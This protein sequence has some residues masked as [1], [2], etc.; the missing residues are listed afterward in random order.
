[1]VGTNTHQVFRSD[2]FVVVVFLEWKCFG[3]IV[4]EVQIPRLS[5]MSYSY[6]LNDD[7]DD[8]N[9]LLSAIVYII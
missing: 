4:N 9:N 5:K 7:D 3:E 1:M 8:D 6:Y 2:V